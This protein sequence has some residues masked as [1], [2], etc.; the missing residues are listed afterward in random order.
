[1]PSAS[2]LGNVTRNEE[3][4]VE[5]FSS[6]PPE[7]ERQL[8]VYEVRMKSDER[9][10]KLLGIGLSLGFGVLFL[11]VILAYWR[12]QKSIIGEE[13]AAPAAEAPVRSVP[14]PAAEA[15]PP[16]APAETATPAAG[17]AAPAEAPAPAA[18]PPA[19]TATPK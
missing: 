9:T 5:N 3:N 8:E 18:A 12:P 14:P 6:F 13:N 7:E 10:A 11:I 17:A 15:T 4:R 19:E 2:R 16:P 1:L